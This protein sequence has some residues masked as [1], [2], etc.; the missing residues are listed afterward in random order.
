MLLENACMFANLFSFFF[1]H[2]NAQPL[3]FLAFVDIRNGK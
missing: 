3:I 1:N 2:K